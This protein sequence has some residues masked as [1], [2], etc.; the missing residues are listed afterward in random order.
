MTHFVCVC[1]RVGVCPCKI[2][3]ECSF[4]IF[5]KEFPLSV[6]TTFTEHVKSLGCRIEAVPLSGRKS[7]LCGSTDWSHRSRALRGTALSQK[8]CNLKQITQKH[9]SKSGFDLVSRCHVGCV[10]RLRWF[11]CVKQLLHYSYRTLLM[12]S[13]HVFSVYLRRNYPL[14]V[15]QEQ[16]PLQ[17]KRQKNKQ[18]KE[19]LATMKTPAS[20]VY[21]NPQ[22]K[23]YSL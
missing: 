21:T 19:R 18:S 23:Q 10:K 11:C 8:N 9:N 13:R 22:W 1:V 2:H 16:T 20:T 3:F 14:Q 7:H 6:I 5:P 4:Y 17:H 12:S 15:W